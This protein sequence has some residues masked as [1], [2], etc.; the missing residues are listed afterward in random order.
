M[1]LNSPIGI[2]MK[3]AVI[4]VM[5]CAPDRSGSRI[6]AD[7]ASKVV[8][9]NVPWAVFAEF[10]AP[11]NLRRAYATAMRNAGLYRFYE[12]SP[13]P[14]D[15]EQA[16]QFRMRLQAEGQEKWRSWWYLGVGVAGPFWPRMPYQV[17]TR[18]ELTA[19]LWHRGVLLRRIRLVESGETVLEYYGPYRVHR[20]QEDTDAV[21]R[22]LIARLLAELGAGRMDNPETCGF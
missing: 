15:R 2:L 5:A 11:E 3:S 7:T 6:L 8:A 16:V 4:L 18:L 22:V 13:S 14:S 21:H 1:K 9:E 10:D 12:G 17:E 19:E 20:V